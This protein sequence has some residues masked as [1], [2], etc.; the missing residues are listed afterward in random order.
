MGLNVLLTFN[1]G[2][3]FTKIAE[4]Q[5][6]GQATA[7]RIG[8][9]ALEDSRSRNPVEPINASATP[10]VFN[11]DLTWNKV[12]Y[13]NMF[14]IEIYANVLNLF[15]TKQVLNVFPTTGTPND[16]GWLKS[17]FA[18]SYKALPNYE[19]FY[20]AINLDNRWA[21]TRVNT[22]GGGGLGG[23]AGNDLFGQP[24][25]IRLGAKIEY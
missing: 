6:L 15:N 17:P 13:L 22:I 24:R 4:P 23:Q 21:Y 9:R 5:N 8:V 2:H 3:N 7:W 20:R 19:A 1:S 18:E 14:N 11:V 12:F 16:D 25:Q 10:W